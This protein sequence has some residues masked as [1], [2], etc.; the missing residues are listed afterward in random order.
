[1][2]LAR[3]LQLTGLLGL[4]GTNAIL[5]DQEWTEWENV[6]DCSTNCGVGQVQQ[7]KDLA[8]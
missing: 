2:S 6:S 4:T 7:G 8:Y 1:M 5:A 3:I